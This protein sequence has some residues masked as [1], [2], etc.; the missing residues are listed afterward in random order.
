MESVMTQP[1]R[2]ARVTW[3]MYDD[4]SDVHYINVIAAASERR[5]TDRDDRLYTRAVWC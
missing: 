1:A 3:E 4:V 2:Y 5:D